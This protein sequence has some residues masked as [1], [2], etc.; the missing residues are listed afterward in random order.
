MGIG[1]TTIVNML[2][3][4]TGY[5][6]F[7]E[8]FELNRYWKDAYEGKADFFKMQIDFL[9]H[10]LRYMRNMKDVKNAICDN[11]FFSGIA[12]VETQKNMG[13]MDEKDYQTYHD[14]FSELKF[15]MPGDSK[16][17]MLCASPASVYDRIC[18]RDRDEEIHVN[19]D[20]VKELCKNFNI[21]GASNDMIMID[22]EKDID[23]VFGEIEKEI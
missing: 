18:K 5:P 7:Q 10:Y 20:Y 3:N 19:I 22:A 16:N 17:F 15:R 23:S 14:F 13:L 12:F 9:T 11:I 2:S 8:L 21:V 4:K 6:V 1:K